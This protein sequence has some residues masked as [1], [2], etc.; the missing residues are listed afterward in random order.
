MVNPHQ[1]DTL[2]RGK[3]MPLAI[4]AGGLGLLVVSLTADV[5]GIGG[6]QHIGSRQL[7]MAFV[8]GVLAVAGIRM[9]IRPVHWTQALREFDWWIPAVFFVSLVVR[10]GVAW[11]VIAH[12]V[13][14]VADEVT[15]AGMATGYDAIY[16]AVL[17]GEEIKPEVVEWA[18]NYGRKA[19]LFPAIL[20]LIHTLYGYGAGKLRV[21]NVLISALT[22]PLVYVLTKRLSSQ[23]AAL[24]A[25]AVHTFYFSFI[26]FSHLLWSESL[27]ILLLLLSIDQMVQSQD[28]ISRKGSYGHAGLAGIALGLTGL[29]RAAMLPTVIAALVW[30]VWRARDLKDR[31]LLALVIVGMFALSLLPWELFLIRHEGGVIPLSTVGGEALYWGNNPFI[32]PGFSACWGREPCRL[33]MNQASQ[34][35]AALHNTS[36]NDAMQALALAEIRSRPLLFVERVLLRIRFLWT[37]DT[38]PLRH[39]LR[40]VYPP[41]SNGLLA[42]LWVFGLASLAFVSGAI[43]LGLCTSQTGLR[44]RGLPLFLIVANIGLPALTAAT[45]RHNLP[46]LALLMP[47]IGHGLAHFSSARRNHQ[48]I[49]LVSVAVVGVSVVTTLPET[50]TIM[51]PSSHY[52]P[53][54]GQASRLPNTRADT[55]DRLVFQSR[56]NQASG[57]ITF[58]VQTDGFF[59]FAD[60]VLVSE[61]VWMLSPDRRE[62]ALILHSPYV[63]QSAEIEVRSTATGE[64]IVLAPINRLAWQRWQATALDD[65]EYM[66][67]THYWVNPVSGDE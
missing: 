23:K 60:E 51:H 4:L 10:L 32:E 47:V 50:I 43:V 38:Y 52:A 66:W 26:A 22:T 63:L 55:T 7:H 30:F 65:I 54:V 25:A 49:A 62:F 5:L 39:F 46:N 41:V 33:R 27:N 59:I 2:Q 9:L 40:V 16:R 21:A 24:L 8:G 18:Y 15:Y 61:T 19:R 37:V 64:A 3:W 36:L 44:N 35:Y 67:V 11:P 17:G 53:L 14:F 29:S 31:L 45:T 42:A 13:P 1:T 58:R 56:N 28:S 34:E 57:E 6:D 48:L 12:D 20:G